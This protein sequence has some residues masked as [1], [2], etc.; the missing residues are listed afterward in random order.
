[1]AGLMTVSEKFGT[2]WGSE[3]L[4]RLGDGNEFP[5]AKRLYQVALDYSPRPNV[6]AEIGCL[7]LLRAGV[8]GPPLSPKDLEEMEPEI[9]EDLFEVPSRPAQ[10]PDSTLIARSLE[11]YGRAYAYYDFWWSSD[12]LSDGDRWRQLLTVNG[13]LVAFLHR[14][15][16]VGVEL[17]CATY[18]RLSD[19]LGERFTDYGADALRLERRFSDA[20]GFLRGMRRRRSSTL[21]RLAPVKQLSVSELAGHLSLAIDNVARRLEVDLGPEVWAML[22]KDVRECL[23]HAEENYLRNMSARNTWAAVGAWRTALEAF[24]IQLEGENRMNILGKY[25][26][27]YELEPKLKPEAPCPELAASI[28]DFASK[29]GHP[30]VHPIRR[31]Y[32]PMGRIDLRAARSHVLHLVKELTNWRR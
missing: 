11:A 15:D 14:G 3:Y 18:R 21:V 5:V 27:D 26:Q 12:G 17:A 7:L 25:R 10:A 29:Y 28:G 19:G 20:N 16:F 8:E 9:D 6:D 2:A 22:S 13:L 32:E 4:I 30:A 23:C 31:R 1:M 24:L